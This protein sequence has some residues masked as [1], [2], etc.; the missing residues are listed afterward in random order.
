MQR[1]GHALV[2]Y[3][4]LDRSTNGI[5]WKKEKEIF[6]CWFCWI[7]LLN[8]ETN[9]RDDFTVHVH[10]QYREL[11][12]ESPG[13][14]SRPSSTS[15][16]TLSEF[17]LFL[18]RSHVLSP[19]SVSSFPQLLSLLPVVL[20]I[21]DRSRRQVGIYEEPQPAQL[22]RST[23]QLL[24]ALMSLLLFAL[25]N[26]IRAYSVSLPSYLL[27]PFTSIPFTVSSLAQHP[28]LSAVYSTQAHLTRV[29]PLQTCG[30]KRICGAIWNIFE[31]IFF[32]CVNE[33]PT[34]LTLKFVTILEDINEKWTLIL[35]NNVFV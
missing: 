35:S 31:M 26:A 19:F 28:S 16:F 5:R 34:L 23:R 30:V 29:Q 33:R 17:N 24:F 4:N 27:V 11:K 32:S 9:E 21:R 2:P 13:S 15:S 7:P 25:L 10:N 20:G 6:L 1:N 18:S 14:L 22:R 8:D 3:K 12:P